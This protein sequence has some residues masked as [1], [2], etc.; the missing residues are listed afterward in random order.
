SVPYS[1]SSMVIARVKSG[2]AAA[3]SPSCQWTIARLFS[4]LVMPGASGPSV[5]SPIA[6]G[7]LQRLARFREIAQ[8]TVRAAER[9]ER[10]HQLATVRLRCALLNRYGFTCE[11]ACADVVALPAMEVGQVTKRNT[12]FESAAAARGVDAQLL[13]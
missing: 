12:G 1:R 7:L 10:V 9:I 5:R 8:T 4:M 11:L 13:F 3:A 2:V 6:S